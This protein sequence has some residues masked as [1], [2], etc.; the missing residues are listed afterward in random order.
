[1]SI[2]DFFKERRFV[3]KIKRYDKSNKIEEEM[4]FE[5]D[6]LELIG[7]INMYFDVLIY[8]YKQDT[9]LFEIDT[10]EILSIIK[11]QNNGKHYGWLT[12]ENK[13][14][15]YRY[16]KK[17]RIYND[18]DFVDNDDEMEDQITSKQKLEL[19]NEELIIL[20]MMGY[21]LEENELTNFV[22]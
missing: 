9:F 17:I 19:D 16:F 6:K 13:D 14:L 7:H 5:F 8:R 3:M 2:I 22:W 4:G 18:L 10:N 1:M 15:P 21:F 20:K 12:V 11:I